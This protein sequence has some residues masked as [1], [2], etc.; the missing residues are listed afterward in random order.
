MAYCLCM[1][2]MQEFIPTV[3]HDYNNNDGNQR[4]FVIV[5]NVTIVIKKVICVFL[6][7]GHER[8]WNILGYF[9]YGH[10]NIF[11]NKLGNS[12]KWPFRTQSLIWCC[13]VCQCGSSS[14]V[15]RR[16]RWCVAIQT[17]YK[18][19]DTSD[20]MLLFKRNIK[21]QI[22]PTFQHVYDTLI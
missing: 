20:G 5:Q 17:Q 10:F 16:S 4:A 7:V 18:K 15:N 19:S 6:Y 12:K 11:E 2:A 21:N 14:V 9:H 3:K 13:L 1:L 8:T 22:L